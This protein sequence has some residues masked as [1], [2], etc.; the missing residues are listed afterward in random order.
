MSL[1]HEVLHGHPTPSRLANL[2]I[3][4]APIHLWLPFAVYEEHHLRH[5]RVDLTLPGIDPESFYFYEDDWQRLTA[6]GQRLQWMNRTLLGRL[7]I[8]PALSLR[9]FLVGQFRECRTSRSLRMI[10]ARHVVAVT[11]VCWL[12]FAVADVPVWQYLIGFVYGGMAVV[13]L[14]SFAEHRAAP[15]ADRRTAIVRSNVFFGVL[16]LYNNLHVTHH[17]LPGAAW[18]HLPRLTREMAAE[19]IAAEGAGLYRGYV[20]LA[21]RYGVKPLTHP[22][23]PLG[24]TVSQS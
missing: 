21:R 2:A 8:G 14:R 20:E 18:Y 1:Q 17:A 10:W 4:W 12:V 6:V 9:S 13:K 23:T 19:Q 11:G 7:T 22:V 24:A 16:F 3:G 15:E 5:H